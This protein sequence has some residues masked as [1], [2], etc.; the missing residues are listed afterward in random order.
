MN[1]DDHEVQ[2]LERRADQL[3]HQL[4]GLREDLQG[5]RYIR[6]PKNGSPVRENHEHDGLV[7]GPDD[8]AGGGMCGGAGLDTSLLAHREEEGI[9]D[10]G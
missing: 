10:A 8:R 4:D 1:A 7:A 2:K 3:Q 5:L 9:E 6:G